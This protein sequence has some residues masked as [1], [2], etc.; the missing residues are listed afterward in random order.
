MRPVDADKFAAQLEHYFDEL[1]GDGE[2]YV[3]SRIQDMLEDA[4]TVNPYVWISVEDRLPIE[5]IR[6]L[7]YLNTDRSYTR[8][9]TDRRFEGKWVR[10]ADD[11][12]YWM[13]LPNPPTEKEI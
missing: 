13:P 7:V 10:W 2:M 5:D 11:V 12:V 4:P 8:I 1:R 6:V 9:D 3:C